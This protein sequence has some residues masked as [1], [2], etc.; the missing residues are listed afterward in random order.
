MSNSTELL[1]GKK[2]IIIGGSSGIGRSVAAA[3]LAHGASVVIASSSQGKV[4]TAIDLLKQGV[5]AASNV[6]L[7]GQA[8]NLKDFA[9][10]KDFLSKEGPFDH[11]VITAGDTPGNNNF[12][13]QEIDPEKDIKSY[14]DV[15]Y[16]ATMIAAQHIYKNKLIN[17][18]GSIIQ[19]I[20]TS[21]YRPLP[22]WG[23]VS[24]LVGAVES[25][26]RGLAVDLKPIRINTICPGLVDTEFHDAYPAEAKEQLFKS[27]RESLPVGHIGTPDEV[28]EAYIFAMK[29]SYL[30]GQVIV[31]DG[32]G[33]LV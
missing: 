11:F 2:V 7:T 20:G 17:P 27:R 8:V 9:A 19:T 24:G 12:P 15:R 33:V 32:G 22:R 6:T 13:E 30:T 16:W 23:L 10:L 21:H 26:T 28:A 18:G 3:T 4:D 25:S 1:K 14:F 5:P 31:V 29:C